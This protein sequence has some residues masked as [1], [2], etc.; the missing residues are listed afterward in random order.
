MTDGPGSSRFPAAL[1]GMRR[2]GHRW[3]LFSMPLTCPY[4]RG[5]QLIGGQVDEIFA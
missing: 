5:S 3:R 2:L 4:S 1:E